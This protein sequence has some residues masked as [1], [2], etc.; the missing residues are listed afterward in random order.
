M[1]DQPFAARWREINAALADMGDKP[2][3]MGEL[4]ARRDLATESPRL[5]AARIAD[6]RVQEHLTP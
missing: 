2:A 3:T 6:Q 1:K 5:T 4:Q